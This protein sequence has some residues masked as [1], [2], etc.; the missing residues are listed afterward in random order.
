MN[1]TIIK[2]IIE[3]KEKKAKEEIEKHKKIIDEE[4]KKIE[5][6]DK[7]LIDSIAYYSA[8]KRN[9]EDY[10]LKDLQGK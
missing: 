9:C 8:V 6:I 3:T 4:N 10:L 2:P 5:E 1:K 7:E